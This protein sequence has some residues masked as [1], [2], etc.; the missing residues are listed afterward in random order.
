MAHVI[1]PEEEAVRAEQ[2]GRG[3][4]AEGEGDGLHRN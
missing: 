4:R 2:Q 1:Y 3:E